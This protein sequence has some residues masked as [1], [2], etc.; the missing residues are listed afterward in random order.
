MD[1]VFLI[2]YLIDKHNY[3]KYLEIGTQKGISF[4]PI[5]CKKKIAVDPDFKIIFRE[6]FEWYYRNISNLRNSYFEMTSDIFFLR[7]KS[8]LKNIGQLEIVLIDGLHTFKA[9]LNDSINVLKY[10]NENGTIILHD[11]FPPHKAASIYANN[12]DEAILKAEKMNG[13]NGEWCG[14]TWKAIAYLKKRYPVE[15]KV[16]VLDCDYG[17]GVIQF[18]R[19][20]N[21]D[22]ILN[23]ELFDEINELEYE[24]LINKPQEIIGLREQENYKSL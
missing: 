3:S 13:W 16:F 15:L 20:R 11:C 19:N 21:L 10:L 22:F 18:K 6:K 24:D 2:Q 4:F 12:A 9:A 5:K 1:R 23:K 17:L 14:D 7:K 8:Y